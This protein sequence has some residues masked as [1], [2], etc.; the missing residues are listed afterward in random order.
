MPSQ[1]YHVPSALYT[2]SMLQVLHTQTDIKLSSTTTE[3]KLATGGASASHSRH[4][5]KI[6]T[7]ATRGENAG[8]TKQTR[9]AS[10]ALLPIQRHTPVA[11]TRVCQIFGYY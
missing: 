1:T 10:C 8:D 11:D 6:L 7:T 3:A 9:Y 5:E 4:T 2:Y